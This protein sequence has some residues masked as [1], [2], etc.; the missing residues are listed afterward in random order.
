MM[1]N[2]IIHINK[3]YITQ[4][5]EANKVRLCA[6]LQY[7]GKSHTVWYE[8][9]FEYKEYLC[10]ERSDSFAV[11]LIL[12]AMEHGYDI[13]CE[14]EM[15][16]SL[17]YHLTEFLIP[18]IAKNI[19]KYKA[20]RILSETTSDKLP[21]ANAV[22]ASVSGGVDSFYT[23]FKNHERKEKTFN[24]THLTFFN[25]GASGTGGGEYARVRFLERIKWIKE[26]SEKLNK[27]IVTVDTNFNEFLKQEHESSHT[28]R[29]LAIPL[30]LQKLFSRY[31][32]ASSYE[33]HNFRFSVTDTSTYDILNTQYL[34]TENL[35]FYTSGSEA[36][37]LEKTKYVSKYEIVRKKLNVC[38]TETTNCSKCDKCKRTILGLYA[39]KE[40]DKFK[41][42]FDISYFN[43]NKHKY[44]QTMY[45]MMKWKACPV[46]SEW[47]D[48][49]NIIKK[50]VTL[51]DRL[52]G[53]FIKI[54]RI[55]RRKIY[56]LD[57]GK[58]L[59]NYLTNTKRGS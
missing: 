1:N 55:L 44:F 36:S 13:S 54:Y 25:A 39:V 43:K 41:D 18:A 14:Q 57:V 8:T 4:D 51:Y 31:F 53:H 52:A 35:T 58:K 59:Y 45:A 47:R 6:D 40:L 26:V 30:A 42:V 56:R 3:P 12:Y 21:N 2:K 9:D 46:A 50:E 27:S 11:N 19:K 7:D 24:I 15:S 16:E 29:T 22:G 17:Y 5:D 37:R 20:I 23:L 33:Y 38:L 28:F 34:S 49:Y 32:F 10:Y 48:I